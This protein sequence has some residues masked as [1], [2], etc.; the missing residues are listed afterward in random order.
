MLWTFPNR[1]VLAFCTTVAVDYN[2][3]CDHG[4]AERRN[5]EFEDRVGVGGIL[6]V[7]MELGMELGMEYRVLVVLQDPT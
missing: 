6:C 7:G 4:Q 1:A 2:R 5:G 3:R